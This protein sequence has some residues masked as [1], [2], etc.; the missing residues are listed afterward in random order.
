MR[1]RVAEDRM[2]A[3][4]DLEQAPL[5]FAQLALDGR[6]EGCGGERPHAAESRDECGLCLRLLCWSR[7]RRR[8]AKRLRR[9]RRA[10]RTGQRRRR[11]ARLRREP[12]DPPAEA[13]VAVGAGYRA[14]CPPVVIRLPVEERRAEVDPARR[15]EVAVVRRRLGALHVLLGPPEARG[16]VRPWQQ[17]RAVATGLD[18]VHAHGLVD[19]PLRTWVPL[20]RE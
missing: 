4:P 17:A 9:A 7:G 8:R 19:D 15:V 3:A 14:G 2:R 1:D 6:I 20:R 18:R 10:T 13:A 16:A 5:E 11:L 12:A